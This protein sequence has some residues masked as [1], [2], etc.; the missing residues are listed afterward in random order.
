MSV[1]INTRKQAI[2]NKLITFQI[3]PF[4]YLKVRLSNYPPSHCALLLRAIP[5][6]STNL[7]LRASVPYHHCEP[8]KEAKQSLRLLQPLSLLRAKSV[9]TSCNEGQGSHYKFLT[10]F[11]IPQ[12]FNIIYLIRHFLK[13]KNVEKLSILL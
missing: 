8:P 3:S 11:K 7:S 12:K 1:K 4:E 9:A 5:W 13:L 10:K 2:N 6:Q